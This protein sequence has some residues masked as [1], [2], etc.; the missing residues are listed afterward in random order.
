MSNA[1][2]RAAARA[3]VADVSWPA[4]PFH[5]TESTEPDPAAI[6]S[7]ALWCS[8]QFELFDTEPLC[9]GP[10]PKDFR[11]TGQVSVVVLAIS[12]R[13]DAAAVA[14]A[15]SAR[16]AV[17]AWDGWPAGFHSE[18]VS[19]PKNFGFDADGNWLRFDV[20]IPYSYDH[21]LT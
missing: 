6:D 3:M 12:G 1:A 13:G 21:V 2:I 16:D 11:E 9:V 17:N 20:E 10:R 15:E 19:A 14:A 7:L 8:L 5:E 18:A 4:I